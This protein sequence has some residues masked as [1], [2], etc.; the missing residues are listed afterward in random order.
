M[1]AV[2]EPVGHVVVRQYE[3]Q[4]D[5]HT[6][7]LSVSTR[8]GTPLPPWAL[9]SRCTRS[10]PAD[11]ACEVFRCAGN[12]DPHELD[13]VP[14]AGVLDV[15]IEE[16]AT[17]KITREV[18]L[19]PRYDTSPVN[20]Y[21]GVATSIPALFA[22]RDLVR[23]S[24]RE[25]PGVTPFELSAP[26]PPN[27]IRFVLPGQASTDDP[28]ERMWGGAIRAS[29][30]LVVETRPATPDAAFDV[31]VIGTHVDAPASAPC[32]AQKSACASVTFCSFP[33]GAPIRLPR[34]AFASMRP[35]SIVSVEL[36]AVKRA[37][38]HA[39]K[40]DIDLTTLGSTGKI[41]YQLD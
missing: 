34:S 2:A 4:N 25:A 16:V 9:A 21:P 26:F 37:R 8:F 19:E 24:A 35:K 22:P 29:E 17:G 31:L 15:E 10:A 38:T 27:P 14:H 20:V 12:L 32:T 7:M 39:G 1:P 3:D 18:S 23:L 13:I 36:A 40:L 41:D 28:T 6:T 30:D 11:G 5:A 33:E